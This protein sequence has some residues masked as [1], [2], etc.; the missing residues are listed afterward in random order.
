MRRY[1]GFGGLVVPFEQSGVAADK[2]ALP[3]PGTEATRSIPIA[4]YFVAVA[5]SGHA[6]RM[7]TS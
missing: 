1:F 5:R 3:F 6:T 7:V 2:L 4:G